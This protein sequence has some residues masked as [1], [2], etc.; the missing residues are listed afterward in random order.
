MTVHAI[1]LISAV[2]LLIL[3]N[4]VWIP[5]YNLKDDTDISSPE[6]DYKG[7]NNPYCD[8][9]FLKYNN[10]MR[11]DCTP[12]KQI[13]PWPPSNFEKIKQGQIL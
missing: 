2:G 3:H 13:Y 11:N 4:F 12:E 9:T 5:R 6:T 1:C 7:W 10:D 8:E